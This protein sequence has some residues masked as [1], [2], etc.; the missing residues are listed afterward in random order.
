M[1]C[2]TRESDPVTSEQAA[3]RVPVR[4]LREMFLA[5]LDALNSATANEI[6]RYWVG[7]GRDDSKAESVRK[8]ASELVKAGKI[9]VVDRRPC[10]VTGNNAQVYERVLPL[11]LQSCA[12]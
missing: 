11:G 2:L 5:S 6:K 10:S 12:L 9:K 8:R 7:A 4:E 1:S 3:E